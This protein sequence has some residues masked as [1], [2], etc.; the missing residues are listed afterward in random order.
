VTDQTAVADLAKLVP[1]ESL[2]DWKLW[3]EF[4][5]AN[6]FA[7]YLPKEFATAISSSSRAA[8]RAW[9]KSLRGGSGRS[10]S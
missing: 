1:A 6:G 9:K 8:W 7:E 2:D 10:A 3:M 5:F 4:H